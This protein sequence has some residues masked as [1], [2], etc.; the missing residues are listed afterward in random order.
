[1]Q[2]DKETNRQIENKTK[3]TDRKIN[4]QINKQRDKRTDKLIKK[5]KT[6]VTNGKNETVRQESSKTE[7]QTYI[8]ADKNKR[9]EN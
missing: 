3:E 7:Q 2:K 8:R 5:K 9:M 4:G 1:M 6:R